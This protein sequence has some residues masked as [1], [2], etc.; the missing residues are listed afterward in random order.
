MLLRLFPFICFL[1]IYKHWILRCGIIFKLQLSQL[2]L[3]SIIFSCHFISVLQLL[4]LWFSAAYFMLFIAS[5]K[6]LV[7]CFFWICTAAHYFIPLGIISLIIL[8]LS[9]C[10]FSA[11]LSAFLL[12]CCF[13]FIFQN[14]FLWNVVLL[15][16]NFLSIFVE[17]LLFLLFHF[18]IFWNL[19]V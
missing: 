1:M 2:S 16:L 13:A 14:Y 11:I 10:L 3:H 6:C 5:P 17:M 8:D 15:D 4:H 7:F 9:Y 12:E 19:A 18:H